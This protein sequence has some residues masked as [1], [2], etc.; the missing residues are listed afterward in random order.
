MPPKPKKEVYTV[1]NK[2]MPFV[3]RMDDLAINAI[4]EYVP[5][6]ADVMADEFVVVEHPQ[7]ENTVPHG[8]AVFAE[9]FRAD[10]QGAI[11]QLKNGYVV[12]LPG[13]TEEGLNEFIDHAM[14]DLPRPDEATKALRRQQQEQMSAKIYALTLHRNAVMADLKA[15]PRR[16]QVMNHL[17]NCTPEAL[18]ESRRCMQAFADGSTASNAEKREAMAAMMKRLGEIDLTK[19]DPT[20]PQ[21]LLDNAADALTVS[22]VGMEVKALVNDAKALGND[23]MRDPRIRP[24]LE[25]ADAM[26]ELS[27]LLQSSM[28]MMCSSA[29]P[30][31]GLEAYRY[32]QP[33]KEITVPDDNFDG[34]VDATTTVS[35]VYG[36]GS[37][38]VTFNSV[39]TDASA[40]L[41]A[42]KM[43]SSLATYSPLM[44]PGKP[45]AVRMEAYLRESDRLHLRHYW[46]DAPTYQ[47]FK[48]EG[49]NEPYELRMNR[50]LETTV[51]DYL[52]RTSGA[53]GRDAFI[54]DFN[55][56]P[57]AVLHQ[58]NRT[59]T[60]DRRAMPDSALDDFI[61]RA[62]PGLPR[63]DA[64]KK[65]ERQVEQRELVHGVYVRNLRQ[66]A[67]LIS[68]PQKVQR[69]MQA[70]LFCGDNS[71][72][73]IAAIRKFQTAFA[74]GSTATV[75]EKR[76]ALAPILQNIGRIDLSGLDPTDPEAI[77][78][79]L[80]DA[81]TVRAVGME[82]GAIIETVKSL[83][84]DFVADPSIRSFLGKAETMHAMSEVLGSSIAMMSS[85]IYP[86][87]G[88]D[89][90]KYYKPDA[91]IT[92]MDNEYVPPKPMPV[93][94]GEAFGLGSYR[95]PINNQNIDASARSFVSKLNFAVQAKSPFLDSQRSFGEKLNRS[96]DTDRFGLRKAFVSKEPEIVTG[97]AAPTDYR[98]ATG[99]FTFTDPKTGKFVHDRLYRAASLYFIPPFH[100]ALRA[101][102]Q[103]MYV[104][105]EGGVYVPAFPDA[106][107]P[108]FPGLTEA[109]LRDIYTSKD[110][111]VYFPAGEKEPV[112]FQDG[113]TKPLTHRL[114]GQNRTDTPVYETTPVR[115][116][117]GSEADRRWSGLLTDTETRKM[118]NEKRAH[119][120]D[121]DFFDLR[122]VEEMQITVYG[123]AAT[124]RVPDTD[125][126][127]SQ[128]IVETMWKNDPKGQFTYPPANGALKDSEIA[129]LTLLSVANPEVNGDKRKNTTKEVS[130]F[131]G[132]NMIV[133]DMHVLRQSTPISS[134]V[135]WAQAG[136]TALA[137][138]LTE[139]YKEKD[140][141]QLAE[142]VA[143][144][145][146]VM[147]VGTTNRSGLTTTT[148]SEMV[149]AKMV[150]EMLDAHP[151]ILEAARKFAAEN[152]IASFERSYGRVRTAQKMYQ[153]AIGFR[154]AE[155]RLFAYEN[156]ELTDAQGRTL[157]PTEEE[158]RT[159]EVEAA[160]L[161]LFDKD[162][163]NYAAYRRDVMTPKEIEEDF[164]RQRE[165]TRSMMEQGA[166]LGGEEGK[167][168]IDA[169]KEKQDDITG[170]QDYVT[171]W[172]DISPL[173][174]LALNHAGGMEVLNTV[175]RTMDDPTNR[176]RLMALLEINGLI[177]PS[178]K[179][180]PKFDYDAA[181]QKFQTEKAAHF[182][183]DVN[184]GDFNATFEKKYG[185]LAKE[186]GLELDDIL[187]LAEANGITP[188]EYAER[189][190]KEMRSA[191]QKYYRPGDTKLST[192]EA[193][194]TK[195]K[196][197]TLSAKEMA[198]HLKALNT[199]S[200]LNANDTYIAYQSGELLSRLYTELH[201]KTKNDEAFRKE[202]DKHLSC[203]DYVNAQE[204]I[205]RSKQ[206]AEML[207]PEKTEIISA[208]VEKTMSDKR[209]GVA[210]EKLAD[211]KATLTKY[212]QNFSAVYGETP[213]LPG[214]ALDPMVKKTTP[215][216]NYVLPDG[217]T[218]HAG[219][220]MI[221]MAML[222]PELVEKFTSHDAFT[223]NEKIGKLV[224]FSS[225]NIAIV[226]ANDEK[227]IGEILEPA[228]LLAKD[229]MDDYQKNH[230]VEKLGKLIGSSLKYYNV[231]FGDSN[232]DISPLYLIDMQQNVD[233]LAMLEADDQLM[234]AAKA[235]GLS[236]KTLKTLRAERTLMQLSDRNEQVTQ[237]LLDGAPKNEEQLRS[238]LC[239]LV[240]YRVACEFV[241]HEADR[242]G[243]VF[244]EGV[245]L[246]AKQPPH[247]IDHGEGQQKV[248]VTSHDNTDRM[249]LEFETTPIFDQ[250]EVG[251][252]EFR[253]VVLNN[254]EFGRL[255]REISASYDPVKLAA[256]KLLLEK[257]VKTISDGL[258]KK[259]IAAAKVQQK[260]PLVK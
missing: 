212:E 47:T 246:D 40:A 205:L 133:N 208:E 239:D 156:G 139:Y 210:K 221:R 28:D 9:A 214:N 200:D 61:D 136:R 50:Q 80:D 104:K 168:L 123:A 243:E 76:D 89:A 33:E 56:D 242:M 259:P 247:V 131:T 21:A 8:E 1:S 152:H 27:S 96:R 84:D 78:D 157:Q 102:L 30:D 220:M 38:E 251:T 143:R 112:V 241:K 248:F 16:I 85:S 58:L 197:P 129:A 199:L 185:K 192:L 161:K 216:S 237:R 190:E 153:Q 52:N 250:M 175:M 22:F 75:Q 6:A 99:H 188:E 240:S 236:D 71:P 203:T 127:F 35:D 163:L 255:C 68:A 42:M 249:R 232:G 217:V 79:H 245:M 226:R 86:D 173:Q 19:L 140:P 187:A 7:G 63:P 10:P 106:A 256:Q 109:Q 43:D 147:A 59:Y 222:S 103:R 145:M 66:H 108:N 32:Y 155:R 206:A 67:L 121:A 87:I 126:S 44:E 45:F 137:P 215:D 41:F 151:E 12:E 95:V 53:A 119:I 196:L 154:Q 132:F 202:L 228:R 24:F 97:T 194:L 204:T 225:N 29:Y 115:F 83:G 234:D 91:E 177:P 150:C 120:M 64:Q 74:D 171:T 62:M 201:N 98:V 105:G 141:A 128:Q 172:M 3:D 55:R 114:P 124:E 233:V 160:K 31:L 244:K 39:K 224:E 219:W 23:F 11:D 181:I 92:I 4:K 148:I 14:P 195:E 176:E 81:V 178:G 18:A 101:D 72:E 37:Y 69:E 193:D 186:M 257:T 135:N 77:L 138:K 26:Y 73:S 13:Y 211:K 180:D 60:V 227:S 170:T 20:D 254:A 182:R 54:A 65:H 70:L 111:Y 169:A 93:T 134:F 116:V 49:T 167:K 165:A 166:K 253:K 113:V 142:T 15:I 5:Q 189:M 183:E 235:N 100:P 146:E 88:L 252:K 118:Q 110:K 230:K 213:F 218:K 17:G 174:E 223:K 34:E 162:A 2:A 125:R 117:Y 158:R 209:V 184:E 46:A 191:S 107:K 207:K 82:M 90:Y 25:K 260:D 238:D 159:L 229:A 130:A 94:V 149:P 48:T 122:R 57:A 231:Q 144:G 198:D 51:T 258:K 164:D 36:H 179:P